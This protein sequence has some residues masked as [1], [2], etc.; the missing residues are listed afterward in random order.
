MKAIKPFISLV[1]SMGIL[2]LFL[3]EKKLQP[4]NSYL[5]KEIKKTI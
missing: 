5:D 1:V 3:K 4:V 2:I